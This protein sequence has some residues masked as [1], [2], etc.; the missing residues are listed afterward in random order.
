MNYNL[1]QGVLGLV[2]LFSPFFPLSEMVH[3][4]LLVIVGGLVLGVS[5]FNMFQK[6]EKNRAERYVGRGM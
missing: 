3:A 2:V 4:V 5:T 6:S 1:I